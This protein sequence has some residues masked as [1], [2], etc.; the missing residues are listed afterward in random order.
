MNA[1]DEVRRLLAS[2]TRS[3]KAQILREIEA[4]LGADPPGAEG[5]LDICG[6]SVPARSGVHEEGRAVGQHGEGRVAAAGREL[7][8]VEGAA[9]PR[10]QSCTRRRLHCK[11]DGRGERDD[12]RTRRTKQERALHGTHPT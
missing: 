2:L 1:L 8:K 6:N 10:R 7:M 9:G 5:T 3:E 4:E 11:R 12:C